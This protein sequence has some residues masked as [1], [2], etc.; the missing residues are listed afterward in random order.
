[1]KSAIVLA[2]IAG[3]VLAAGIAWIYPPAGVIALG[4]EGLI[5]AYMRAYLK[6][7]G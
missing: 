5:A 6:A 1:M 2:V 3:V 4:I 7:R